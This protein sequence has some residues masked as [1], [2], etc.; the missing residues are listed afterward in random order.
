MPR[1]ILPPTGRTWRAL[2]LSGLLALDLVNLDL[3]LRH[4]FLQFL[5]TVLNLGGHPAEKAR[6]LTQ[7]VGPARHAL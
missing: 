4:F 6:Q 2:C 3:Q 1:F 5:L 7:F